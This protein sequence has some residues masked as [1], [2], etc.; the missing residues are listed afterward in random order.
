MSA[1]GGEADITRTCVDV[2]FKATL[3]LN[4]PNYSALIPAKRG[5]CRDSRWNQQECVSVGWGIHHCLSADVA[6]GAGTVFD[7]ELLTKLYR[8]PLAYQA[9]ENVGCAPGGKA[10]NDAHRPRR[11]VFATRDAWKSQKRSA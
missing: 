2:R 11:I 1:F 5:I 4:A 3:A 10:D 8:Q 9:G 6:A 7:D